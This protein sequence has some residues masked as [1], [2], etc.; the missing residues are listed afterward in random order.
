MLLGEHFPPL[1][2]KQF[3]PTR[4]DYLAVLDAHHL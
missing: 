4:G 1:R 3:E 2:I